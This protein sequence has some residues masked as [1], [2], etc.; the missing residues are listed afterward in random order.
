MDDSAAEGEALFPAAGKG[1]DSAV[2]VRFEAGEGEDF[3]DTLGCAGAGDA[4][5]A[6]VEAEVLGYGEVFVEAELLRHIADVALDVGASLRMSMPRMVPVPSVGVM[7][8]QRALMM[9]VLPVP[10]SPS[11]R[12]ICPAGRPPERMSSKPLT[13]VSIRKGV[14]S[15]F[16]CGVSP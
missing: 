4:V 5:N 13:P 11:S 2:Q 15:L 16:I 8:P 12:Y 7:S 1:V 14:P 9:V 3:L 6:R 10:G